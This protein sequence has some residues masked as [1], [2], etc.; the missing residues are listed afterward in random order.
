[1]LGRITFH[2]KADKDCISKSF[3][4]KNAMFWK[5]TAFPFHRC[6]ASVRLSVDVQLNVL[7][8]F[9]I[10]TPFKVLSSNKSCK[11][12]R[13]DLFSCGGC[14]LLRTVVEQAFVIF[15]HPQNYPFPSAGLEP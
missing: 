15:E 7:Y 3:Q 1:M 2:C 9:I 11:N 5:R 12:E 14:S 4:A 8:H 10:S 6:S 13:L